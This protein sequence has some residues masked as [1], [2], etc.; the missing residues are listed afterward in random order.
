MR[1]LG[2]CLA[3]P[4]YL[5]ADKGVLPAILREFSIHFCSVIVQSEGRGFC[6]LCQ[7][8]V[9]EVKILNKC[10]ME[11]AIKLAAFPAPV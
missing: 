11:K 4:Q 9:E 1:V 2:A 5:V 10:A 8:T 6:F 7:G 3:E